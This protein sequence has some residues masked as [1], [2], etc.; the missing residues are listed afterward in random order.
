M[1]QAVDG[2][3]LRDVLE[4][5]LSSGSDL[6]RKRNL[7]RDLG[8]FLGQKHGKGVAYRD[9]KGTNLIVQEKDSA[10]FLFCI[11]DFDGIFL[12]T[13]SRRR[14]LNNVSRLAREFSLHRGVT[15]TDRLRFLKSY[16]GP[17]EEAR[18]KRLW[19]YATKR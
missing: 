4:S 9:L 16:L 11:V 13:L 8:S 18:W 5:F 19:S 12:G 2:K 1:T 17:K 10:A 7:I 6:R 15:R 14:R 3:R